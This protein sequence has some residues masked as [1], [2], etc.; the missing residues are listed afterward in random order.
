[1]KKFVCRYIDTNNEEKAVFFEGDIVFD[2]KLNAVS[3]Q[4]F[5]TFNQNYFNYAGVKENGL[6]Y[7]SNNL[8][9][10]GTNYRFA[11]IIN[12][13]ENVFYLIDSLIRKDVSINFNDVNLNSENLSQ[14]F[15]FTLELI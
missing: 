10:N 14:P 12:E 4:P 11:A 13:K 3:G 2:Y 6:S 7:L 8:Q 9:T 5:F 1:M 15:T